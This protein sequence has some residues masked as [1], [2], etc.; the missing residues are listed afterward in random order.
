MADSPLEIIVEIKI[1]E[2]KEKIADKSQFKVVF[3]TNGVFSL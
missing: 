1:V 3:K 2:Y